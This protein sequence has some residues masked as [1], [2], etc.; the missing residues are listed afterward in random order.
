MKVDAI[1]RQI[2]I[3]HSRRRQPKERLVSEVDFVDD[4]A[5]PDYSI[6]FILMNAF[7]YYEI[8]RTTLKAIP[9]AALQNHIGILR[10][11]RLEIAILRS[12]APQQ[13]VSRDLL[14]TSLPRNWLVLIKHQRP[15]FIGLLMLSS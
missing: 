3:L 9:E 14:L 6:T 11:N 2:S 10:W 5:S 7:R 13:K 15:N 12:Q 4:H 8:S 1:L